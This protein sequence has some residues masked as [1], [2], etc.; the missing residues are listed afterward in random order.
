MPSNV[1][2]ASMLW[3]G[4]SINKNGCTFQAVFWIFGPYTVAEH[5]RRHGPD[6]RGGSWVLMTSAGAER[7]C[8]SGET[9]AKRAP[10]PWLPRPAL[11]A[12]KVQRRWRNPLAPAPPRLLSPRAPHGLRQQPFPP[13]SAYFQSFR[14]YPS[15]APGQG[16]VTHGDAFSCT[17]TRLTGSAP[18]AAPRS[19][20]HRRLRR[21][22]C[23]SRR[24]L[25]IAR[26]ERPPGLGSPEAEVGRLSDSDRSGSVTLE[27]CGAWALG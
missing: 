9:R 5:S 17:G 1:D 7:G 27:R 4:G 25:G 22:R 11:A 3:T 15:P 19:A 24:A 8:V 2:N 13:F 12:A 23:A 6:S 21:R 16:I 26:R 10:G 20:G 18:R 14:P